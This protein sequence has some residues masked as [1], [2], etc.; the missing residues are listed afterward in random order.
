MDILCA[1]AAICRLNAA[2]GCPLISK[3]LRIGV[4]VGTFDPVHAGHIAFA[5][6]AIQSAELHKVIFLPERRPHRR[7]GPEH[8][9]HRVVMLTH[10]LEPHVRMSVLEVPEIRFSTKQT[11]PQLQ[12]RYPTAQFA[13][14]VGEDALEEVAAWPHASELFRTAELIINATSLDAVRG[15]MSRIPIDPRK[16]HVI[17]SFAADIR[18]TKVRQAI[19]SGSYTQGLLTSV[20]NYAH[21]EWLYVSSAYHVT[22]S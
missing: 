3:P 12:M 1:R 4:Y 21:R 22:S 8:Y 5:L 11:V 18:S 20:R 7:T 13:Y 19:R 16:V 10:A 14:L 6:Q 15:Q 9:A 17:S 2:K